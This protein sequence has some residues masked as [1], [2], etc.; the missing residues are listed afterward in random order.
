MKKGVKE[1]FRNIFFLG[2]SS[3]FNDIG[4]E[5]ITPII[6][7]YTIALGGTGV[8]V[9]L[10]S[11]LREGLSSLF[12]IFG[13]WFSDRI[14]KR[15][16][17]VFLGYF[18]S[19]IFKFF[20]ALAHSWQAIISFISLERFGKLRD[21]PRDVIITQ[22]TKKIGKGFA[23][24]QTMDTSGAIIGTLLVIF[25]FWKLQLEIQT[26]IFI[27]AGISALAL[28]PLF[29]VKEVDGKKTKL[30]F[31]RSIKKISPR[32][33]YF[34]FVSS[35]FTLANFGLYMFL[36]LLVKEQTGNIIIPLIVYGV[37]SFVYA[38]FAVPFG[39]LS[40]K[41]GRK[42]VLLMGYVLFFLIALTFVF[43]HNI[44]IL[45]SLFILYGLVYAITQPNQKAFVSDLSGK[46]KGTALG[47]YGS[48]TGIVNIFGG[49][50]AGILWDINY[51]VMFAF[52]SVVAFVSIILLGFVEEKDKEKG[53][54]SQQN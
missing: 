46:M 45:I 38:V 17:F 44:F 40:D 12:K 29:F 47:F 11:G 35:V 49:L 8:A 16:P 25:L 1:S 52:I 42:K 37:F 50:I 2:G 41:I 9:G 7:F 20:L 10:I 22:S 28:I 30:K 31:L 13:G 51:V 18:L 36:L 43:L 53:V 24:H 23:L 34:V 6:P 26:I 39:N 3:F 27:A 48:V 19:V 15:K 54:R 33:K 14:G 5:M 32:L 4:S 21:A